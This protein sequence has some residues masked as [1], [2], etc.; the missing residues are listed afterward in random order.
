MEAEGRSV[1]KE[2]KGLAAVRKVEDAM[3]KMKLLVV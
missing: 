3:D 1:T 2:E